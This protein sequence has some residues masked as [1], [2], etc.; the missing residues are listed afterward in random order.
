M[1]CNTEGNGVVCVAN[2]KIKKGE[3]ICENYGLM[4]TMKQRQE[5]REILKSHYK[6]DC[7]CQACQEDWP[8]LDEMR[9]AALDSGLERIREFHCP[10][11]GSKMS[12]L[13]TKCS[14]CGE[15][16]D[17]DKVLSGLSLLSKSSVASL[18]QGQWSLGLEDGVQCHD[19]VQKHFKD[20]ILELT[21]VQIAIWKCMW[22]KVGNLRKVKIL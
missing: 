21:E 8:K 5:R 9:S 1:R 14:D 15:E 16:V 4:Y 6:F 17:F 11:C 18:I 2:R 7:L 12:K 3:E 20:P 22:I 13:I 19:L 10:R